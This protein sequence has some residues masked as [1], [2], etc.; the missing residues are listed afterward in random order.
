[1]AQLDWNDLKYA[2]ALADART[3]TAAARRLR[4]SQPTVG[5]RI[6]ALED[7]LGVTLF[8]RTPR[9]YVGTPAGLRLLEG[10]GAL[11]RQ[12]D[13]FERGALDDPGA[14][15]GIVRLAVT[16]VTASYLLEGTLLRLHKRYPQIVCELRAGNVVADL[17]RGDAD[18]AVR[19]VK[20]EGSDL[21]VRKLGTVVYSLYASPGYL[22]RR[23]AP[24]DLRSLSGHDVVAPFDELLA[25]PEA[26]WLGP[27]IRGGAPSLRINS[28]LGLARAAVGGMGLVVLATTI[29][30]THPGL[31]AISPLRDIA[32]RPV[33]LVMHR[34]TRKVGRIRAV[35]DAV[36]HDIE[37]RLR[38]AQH[39]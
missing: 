26:R 16:E 28:V 22:A 19:L 1:M 31:Q 14:M 9:G 13:A 25:G 5:R 30:M 8:R 15:R 12:L 38:R 21:V 27:E 20:P 17:A 34:D 29:G 23:G 18:L 4:V 35:A 33:Y 36:V 32:P 3:L 7:A 10:I 6:A 24:D 11:G 39:A 37:L 2:V